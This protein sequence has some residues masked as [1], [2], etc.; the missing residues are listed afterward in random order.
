LL[1]K[2]EEIKKLTKEKAESQYQKIVGA[3]KNLRDEQEHRQMDLNHGAD[4]SATNI[5]KERRNA[6]DLKRKSTFQVGDKVRIK[7]I[8]FG[9]SYAKGLPEFT[10]RK[11][12]KIKGKKAGVVYEAGKE[13]YDAYL[14]HLEKLGG[15]D[16]ADQGDVVATV[17]YNGKWYKRT[18]TFYSI[19]ATLEVGSALKRS[20]ES[21]ESSWPRD[22]FE[23][24]VRDDWR[25]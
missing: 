24:L 16:E 14:A 15:D 23:A 8:R 17:C 19:M 25:E 12:V 7:T 2:I 10:Q 9:K 22:F 4:V 11:V 20:E 18:Q 1:E 3:V 6:K 13:I 5:L 21:E